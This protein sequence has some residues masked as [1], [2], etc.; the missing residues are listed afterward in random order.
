M[1]INIDRLFD[2]DVLD[3]VINI[4]RLLSVDVLNV[5]WIAMFEK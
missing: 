2:V 1:L 5:E 3:I 4:D